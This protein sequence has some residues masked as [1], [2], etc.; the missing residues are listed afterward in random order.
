MLPA[1]HLNMPPSRTTHLQPEA[2]ELAQDCVRP[3]VLDAQP[4]GQAAWGVGVL[5]ED[6][7]LRGRG[8]VQPRT[9]AA[10]SSQAQPLRT[11]RR[12]AEPVMQALQSDRTLWPPALAAGQTGCSRPEGRSCARRAPHQRLPAANPCRE[13]QRSARLQGCNRAQAKGWAAAMQAGVLVSIQQAW[14][15]SWPIPLCRTTH[16][17]PACVPAAQP[18]WRRPPTAP[19]LL[20]SPP[21]PCPWLAA[22]TAAAH[23]R[24]QGRSGR[25][26][27]PARGCSGP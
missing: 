11:P 16:P 21:P 23:Q 4:R 25:P 26:G 18:R 5:E 14:V 8:A 2:H 13:H 19:H 9:L 1:T 6:G 24:P 10:A 27:C 20:H 15:G 3:Q 22:Q 17:A 7:L 12:L